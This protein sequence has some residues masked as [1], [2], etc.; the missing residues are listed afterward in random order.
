V[1]SQFHH[2][3]DLAPTVLEVAGLPFPTSV[4]GTVQKPFEGVSFAYTFDDAKA[5]DRHTTQYFEITGNRGIYHEGWFARTIHK[6]PWEPKPRAT[7]EKDT[8]ELYDTRNDFSLSTDVAAAKPA[9]LKELQEL[10]MKEAVKYNVL[11]L[12]DR[13]LERADPAV[14]GR[15]DL[16]QGRTSLTLFEGMTGMMENTFLNVKGRSVTITAEVD[17][18][19]SG[20]NGVILAQGGRFGGWSLYVKD[21]KPAY[22]YNCTGLERYTV[23]AKEPAAAGKATITLDFAYDGGARGKGGTATLSV[24]GK[25]VAEGRI[26]N[27]NAVMFSMDE[28]ADVGMDEDTPVTE[29]YV[30]GTRSRFTGQ[31][32]KVTVDLK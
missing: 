14:A 29:E 31:I 2:V 22:A 28:G 30:A 15:P 24:N 20:A 5:R 4:N 18:P 21:G 6:A 1:R 32:D 11:P 7:L 16:M 19:Q 8:W 3:I 13:L 27:T 9:K 26:E 17:I 12:D 23:A 25:K 10:F